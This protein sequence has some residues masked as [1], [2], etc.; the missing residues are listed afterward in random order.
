[1]M[2]NEL[3]IIRDFCLQWKID[4]S[5]IDSLEEYGLIEVTIINDEQYI[6]S[7]QLKDLERYTRFY[8]ELSINMEGIDVIRHLLDQIDTLQQENL[9]LKNQLRLL[10]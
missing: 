1:M 9:H 10:F 4:Q 3:I 8:Y 7:S 6:Y 5:F 2:E